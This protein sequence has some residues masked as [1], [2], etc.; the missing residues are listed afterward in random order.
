MKYV[1]IAIEAF[2]KQ[3]LIGIGT[4]ITVTALGLG[5][6]WGLKSIYYTP[7][8]KAELAQCAPYCGPDGGRQRDDKCFCET[9]GEI[10]YVTKG[11]Q[12]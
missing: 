11:N 9:T 12:K 8:T 3:C 7:P 1:F 6:A 10:Y 5:V 4:V 2:I